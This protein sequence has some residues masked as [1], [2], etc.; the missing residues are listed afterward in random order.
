MASQKQIKSKNVQRC[1]RDLIVTKVITKYQIVAVRAMFEREDAEKTIWGKRQLMENMLL[2]N[3]CV[4]LF[5]SCVTMLE[6]RKRKRKRNDGSESSDSENDDSSDCSRGLAFWVAFDWPEHN[7]SDFECVMTKKF[8]EA[9]LQITDCK[10][11][12]ARG[13]LFINNCTAGFCFLF[14]MVILLIFYLNMFTW[15]ISKSTCLLGIY[16]N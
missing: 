2:E 10:V 9:G 1:L 4:G 15:D 6:R 8:L 13:N 3:K 7:A 5:F 11:I 16:P 12:P 14:F